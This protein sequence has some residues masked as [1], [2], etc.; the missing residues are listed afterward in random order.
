MRCSNRGLRR[1]AERSLQE[2]FAD[3]FRAAD[4]VVIAAVFRSSLPDADRLSEEQ[5]VSDI[6]ASASPARYVP[7]VAEIVDLLVGERREG[8]QVVLMSNGGFGGIHGKLPRRAA[9]RRPETMSERA[10][11]AFVAAFGADRVRRHAPLA[12]LDDVPSGWA[13]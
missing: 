12:P 11:A 10:I 2:A 4:D 8:D 9:S 1:P 7:N 6:R 5:L 13:G 3:S